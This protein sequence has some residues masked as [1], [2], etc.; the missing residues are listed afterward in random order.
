MA[1]DGMW[2][3]Q[4]QESG[5]SIRT[6]GWRGDISVYSQCRSGEQ[7]GDVTFGD[8]RG[9][10]ARWR[11]GAQHRA[12]GCFG[13]AYL[14]SKTMSAGKHNLRVVF[15][16]GGI[17]LD[18]FM[19]AKDGD[20]TNGVK[21]SDVV[22][23]RAATDGMLIAPIV[24]YEH[25]EDTAF[26]ANSPVELGVPDMSDANAHA[27]TEYQLTNW[28]G[29]PLYQDF[30]R[31]SSRYWDIMVDQLL[32]SRAQVPFIHCRETA[33]YTNDLQDRAYAPGG[34]WYEGRWMKKLSEA[35]ARSPQAAGALKVGMFWESGGIA[36][37]F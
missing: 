2:G 31:R 11:G 21:A 35:A 29:V 13:Y 26:P 24:G 33:D 30:D 5:C 4:R 17:S 37:G 28:Y 10:G 34:G 36:T 19:L 8:R 32:A 9:G 3:T 25:H 14:G 20:T 23:A 16:T 1:A 12:V 22:L 27:Y 15:E 18:W 7:R 6:C